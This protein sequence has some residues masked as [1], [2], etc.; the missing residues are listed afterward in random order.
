MCSI[1]LLRDPRRISSSFAACD[2]SSE[3]SSAVGEHDTL[4]DEGRSAGSLKRLR[5]PSGAAPHWD[6]C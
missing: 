2:S 4:P 5:R 3:A 6:C 1:L